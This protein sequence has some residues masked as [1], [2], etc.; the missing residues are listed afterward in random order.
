MKI[1]EL[2][3]TSVADKMERVSVEQ[4]E[5]FY[6]I[7]EAQRGRTD[8][9]Q[10]GFSGP[11]TEQQTDSYSSDPDAFFQ[12]LV[13]SQSQRLDDQRVA[14]SSLPGMEAFTI[15]DPKDG[16]VLKTNF[17]Q[18]CN[19]VSKANS[20]KKHN[21]PKTSLSPG[22]QDSM[23]RSS[24]NP[25]TAADTD[26][27]NTLTTRSASYNPISDKDR[28]DYESFQREQDQLLCLVSQAQ[29]RRMDEQRCSINPLSP[30][31]ME[32]T[33]S[34]QDV[35]KFFKLI[36][37]TQSRRFDDQRATLN[38][39]P[40]ITSPRGITAADSDHLFSMVSRIQGSRIDDQRCYA[41]NIQL[42]SPAPPKKSQSQPVSLS[43]SGSPPKSAQRSET[44]SPASE[45]Q[46]CIDQDQLFS[47]VHHAQQRRMDD[48]RCSFEPFK[49]PS[50]SPN[51]SQTV[52]DPEQFFKLV[53]NCQSRRLDDQRVTLSALPG[54]QNCSPGTKRENNKTLAPKI[55]LTPASPAAPKKVCSRSSSPTLSVSE[56]DTPVGPPPRSA[57]YPPERLLHDDLSA[58]ISFQISMCFPPHQTHGPNNQ[59]C[60]YPEIFLTV[61]Q[62]GEAIVIPL[63]PTPGR[64]LSLN[65][66]PPGQHCSR[67]ASPHRSPARQ[68]H[69]RSSSPH[70]GNTASPM[71]PY[72]DYI[73]LNQ[74][75]YSTQNNVRDRAELN[76]EAKKGKGKSGGKKEKKEG[77]K[78]KRR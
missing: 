47:L 52:E 33:Q 51:T 20:L 54:I 14:L 73:S 74:R 15:K 50:S 69:S 7:S 60:P 38:Q 12:F 37:S 40:E 48:Q 46:N 70:P 30:G 36:A 19:L 1:V 5:M 64:P 4:D 24:Y 68:G 35:E 49:K 75:V 2:D 21:P 13:K 61:G 42:G 78:E 29:S 71:G 3:M 55:T 8:E 72:E 58:Q 45:I 22:A 59:P 62:Q 28:M 66:N 41:P 63:S 43:G 77:S 23:R 56:P 9:E 65:V 25:P 67:S 39:L 26:T 27:Y 11:T 17:Y 18:I 34:D 16:S 53:A 76:K 57:S 44:F 10:R 6:P 31:R 32:N